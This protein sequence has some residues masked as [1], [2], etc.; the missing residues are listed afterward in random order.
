[1]KNQG[2][3]HFK[4]IAALIVGVLALIS[5]SLPALP[6]DPTWDAGGGGN[7]SINNPG[8]WQGDIT[9]DLVGGTQTLIFGTAGSRASL[10]I[11]INVGGI[12]INRPVDFFFI[13][14]T[15]EQAT[16]GAGGILATPSISDTVRYAFDDPVILSANQ[17]WTVQNTGNFTTTLEVLGL[18][19]NF[20]LTKNGTG[21]ATILENGT[22]SGSNTT[23]VNQGILEL[24][25]ATALNTNAD[26]Q[27]LLNG[28]QLR[29]AND[30]NTTFA[31]TNIT[32]SA[33]STIT[34][35]RASQS[36]GEVP[37]HTVGNIS[38]G[39]RTLTMSEGG[40]LQNTDLGIIQTGAVTLT[41]NAVFNVVN[42]SNADALF[43]LGAIGQTGGTR[44]L[45]KTGNGTLE[46]TANN[47]FTGNTTVAA[48][49][50]L[51]NSDSSSSA[52]N[53]QN[54][55][56]IGGNGT[57]GTLTLAN[58]A[59]LSPGNS[60]GT[61]NVQGDATWAGGSN[62]NWQVASLN[63][64]ASNQ[65]S[66]GINWDFFSVNGTL[67][68]AG[69]DSTPLNFNIW[70]LSS[71]SPETNGI[72]PGWATATDNSTWAIAGAT[73]GIR[74]NNVP[75]LANT[76]YTSLFNINTTATNGAGGWSGTIP[77]GAGFQIVT[78]ADVN[79]LYL[80][81]APT[82]VPEPG[83]IAA[84]LL[85]VGGIAAYFFLKRRRLQKIQPAP[86]TDV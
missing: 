76:N 64:D 67:N 25:A 7:R 71:L 62:Y 33:N 18:E 63:E 77:G 85:L 75:L 78:L 8:N 36:P 27:L 72:V 39:A 70:S 58:G 1:M 11:P 32:V 54:T 28:G 21:I 26:A 86:A 46:F 29:L 24:G 56:T 15:G 31:G 73:G 69:L 81:A 51:A 44:T 19:G 79:T 5:S 14:G 83:Q 22:R 41:G 23:T 66:K 30:Q 61:L 53:V 80:F 84:S 12:V 68:L 43:K 34:T 45:T 40:V 6:L 50:L 13:S 16:V 4:K 60:P 42:N 20:N 74:L 9:P 35:T 65:T 49:T 37:V 59:T 82:P 38:I 3:K 10:N 57:V 17:T 52:V 2:Y 48:G 47:S 55:A